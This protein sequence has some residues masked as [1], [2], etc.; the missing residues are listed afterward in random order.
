MTVRLCSGRAEDASSEPV[1]DQTRQ[2]SDVIEM[3]VRQDD[4]GNLSR[5]N[6]KVLPIPFRRS[7]LP[8]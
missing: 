3:R 1:I 6:W 2:V 7:S 8:H 5:R 4:R